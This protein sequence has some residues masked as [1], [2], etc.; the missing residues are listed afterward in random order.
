MNIL[1]LRFYPQYEPKEIIQLGSFGGIY[2]DPNFKGM[3]IENYPKDWFKGLND[4]QYCSS[5]YDKNVNLYKVKAGFNQEEW[6]KRGW[7]DASA[8]RGWFQWYCN[9][10][11]G[12]ESKHDKI[13]IQRWINFQRWATRYKSLPSPVI[14]QSLLHW[15]YKVK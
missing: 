8:P 12:K 2:F 3:H 1:D 9:L 5:T 7:I 10:W 13:Q 14:A 4:N 6:D 11:I 15:A